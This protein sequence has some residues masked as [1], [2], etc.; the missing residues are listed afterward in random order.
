MNLTMLVATSDVKNSH[1]CT[2]LQIQAFKSFMALATCGVREVLVVF[3]IYFAVAG[4]GFGAVP[5][6]AGL[7]LDLADGHLAELLLVAP[8]W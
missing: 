3:T 2:D 5:V 6:D 1:V 4:V 7:A 8:S